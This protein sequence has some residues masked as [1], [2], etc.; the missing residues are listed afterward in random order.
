MSGVLWPLGDTLEEARTRSWT[1]WVV[2]E[3]TGT[4]YEIA[5]LL[6]DQE[7]KNPPRKSRNSIRK[8]KLTRKK[9]KEE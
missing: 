7:D 4:V 3:E 1:L 5:V 2:D 6:I 9:K 8:A